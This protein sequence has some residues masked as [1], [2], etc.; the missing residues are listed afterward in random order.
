MTDLRFA[1]RLLAADPAV[2]RPP[3]PAETALGPAVRW[4]TL[5]P[6]VA[7]LGVT[8]LL[9][10]TA[11]VADAPGDPAM[12]HLAALCLLTA[13]VTG[14]SAGLMLRAVWRG[15]T[16]RPRSAVGAAEFAAGYLAVAG[17]LALSLAGRVPTHPDVRAV[18]GLAVVGAA[19]VWVRAR[20]AR[21][22]LA[23]AERLLELELR[24]A[25]V[26]EALAAGRPPMTAGG[27]G[28]PAA[29]PEPGFR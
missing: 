19:A 17:G 14:L 18:G 6:A 3:S 4:G 15:A 22:E 26:Q 8:G 10:H 2:A 11:A 23:A 16:G 29:G 5:L 9:V 28:S 21:A 1:D 7:A 13:G 24:L 20:V 27:C 12:P 25:E